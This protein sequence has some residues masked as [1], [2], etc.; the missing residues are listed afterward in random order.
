MSKR[1]DFCTKAWSN[2]SLVSKFAENGILAG[3]PLGLAAFL[4]GGCSSAGAM[5]HQ[6]QARHVLR[7]DLDR[8][9]VG[10][11]D[12]RLKCGASDLEKRIDAA[13]SANDLDRMRTIDSRD[14]FDRL[15]EI[16]SAQGARLVGVRRHQFMIRLAAPQRIT[17]LRQ[18]DNSAQSGYRFGAALIKLRRPLAPASWLSVH[19]DGI[20]CRKLS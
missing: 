2:Q 9:A 4:G 6:K 11:A 10:Q 18:T 1:T 8:R 20:A 7:V 3:L 17:F 13:S 19:S 14:G 5:H 12:K 16:A 15:V